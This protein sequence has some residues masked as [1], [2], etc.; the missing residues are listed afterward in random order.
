M[1]LEQEIEAI[2]KLDD[3]KSDGRLGYCVAELGV[4][5]IKFY[6]AAPQMVS[7]IR[8]LEA[9][10]EKADNLLTD[11][12]NNFAETDRTIDEAKLFGNTQNFIY[13]WDE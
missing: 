7:I 9:K 1:T 8:R 5:D 12:H 13:G 11:W 10:L 3:E 2:Y 6:N 4:S